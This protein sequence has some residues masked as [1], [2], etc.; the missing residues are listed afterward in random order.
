MFQ[1]G[2]ATSNVSGTSCTTL[3][4]SDAADITDYVQHWADQVGSQLAVVVTVDCLL[5]M[6]GLVVVSGTTD[7][8][9]PLGD[10]N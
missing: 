7:A 6:R 4:A 10:V 2:V 9:Y 1:V 3:V 8:D 5:P